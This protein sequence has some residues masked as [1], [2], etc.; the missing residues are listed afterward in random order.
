M[1]KHC[2]PE[3]IEELVDDLA[4]LRE[5]VEARRHPQDTGHPVLSVIRGKT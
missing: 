3:R 1:H 4:V 5:D 2:R